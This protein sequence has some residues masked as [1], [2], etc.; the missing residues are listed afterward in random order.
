MKTNRIIAGWLMLLAQ[1]ATAQV[2][3]QDNFAGAMNPAWTFVRQDA[4][5]YSL[6]STGLVLRCNS[7]DL[8]QGN[9]NAKNVFLITNTAP[10]D[11]TLTLRLRWLVPPA[12]AYAQVDLLAYDDD[13][14]H[15]RPQYVFTTTGIGIANASEVGGGY[16]GSALTG[17][18]FGTNRFWLQMQKAGLTYSI[19]Y[20]TNGVNF[21]PASAAF[22]Y[23]N[24]HPAKLGFVA[25]GD[26][27][28]TATVFID[29]FT[30]EAGTPYATLT[31]AKGFIPVSLAPVANALNG[32]LTGCPTGAQLLG[33]VPFQLL[34]LTNNC[35][36]DAIVGTV[37]G[38]P[39]TNIMNLPVNIPNATA[40]DMLIN[41]SW[42][43]Y[44]GHYPTLTFNCSDGFSCTQELVP[45]ADVRDWLESDFVN[46]ANNT[47]TIQV[48]S[49]LAL[50]FPGRTGRIDKQHIEL[51]AAFARR[52]LT[53]IVLTDNGVTGND[54][55]SYSQSVH[56]Q[57][58]FIYGVTVT[59]L[60]NL[61]A[62]LSGSHVLLSWPLNAG[63]NYQLQSSTNLS[64]SNWVNEGAP[65]IG[66]AG[67]VSTNMS[68]G[69][70]PA[71]FFRLQILGN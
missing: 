7:G 55:A 15:V 53:S 12:Q 1:V 20:S 48:Y 65:F 50:N 51:P 61:Q 67:V 31:G 21:L 49:A 69:P 13:D 27:T 44:G 54:D 70:E 18:D 68:I 63:Y 52:T 45:G 47:N 71:K 5:Y 30:V 4:S 60:M 23:A 32:R 2:I 57:R 19:W 25:M 62:Q 38:Q 34:P 8:Y 6:Q 11:F 41:L 58:V 42:G 33:G 24:P 56:A 17:V 46:T 10:A 22:S 37:T 16:T 43:Y 36:W 35:A 28:E 26:P 39:S 66:A 40:V 9:N 64:V 14:N 3:F 59:S 29:S